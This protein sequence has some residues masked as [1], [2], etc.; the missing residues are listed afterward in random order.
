MKCGSVPILGILNTAVLFSLLQWPSFLCHMKNILFW[1]PTVCP[2]SFVDLEVVIVSYLCQW[3]RG[4]E[5]L[6]ETHR[7]VSQMAPCSPYSALLLTRVPI[8]LSSKVVHYVE[9][10]V[11]LGTWPCISRKSLIQS[12]EMFFGFTKST[13]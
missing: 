2:N 1:M 10:R 5:Y 3:P 8:G 4:S 9:N 11:P 7:L 6:A 13:T 12:S